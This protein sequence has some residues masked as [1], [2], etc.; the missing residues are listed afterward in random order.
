[1]ALLP[2]ILVTY[3][4]LQCIGEFPCKKC[5]DEGRICSIW[6]RK[7]CKN[8]QLTEEYAEV[9]DNTQ[10]ALVAMV[11]KLYSMVRERQPWEL[12]EPELN[13]G[14]QPIIHD[15]ASKLGCV[16]PNNN[17]TL[18][19]HSPFPEDE[20]G[21]ADLARQL[22]ERSQKECGSQISSATV[23]SR[24]PLAKTGDCLDLKQDYGKPAFGS[25][26]ASSASTPTTSPASMAHGSDSSNFNPAAFATF[27]EPGFLPGYPLEWAWVCP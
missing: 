13:D 2:P 10:H 17:L 19:V 9:L 23:S 6:A 27:S 20:A 16:Q 18:P 12:G 8:R 14:G 22:S 25:G 26:A 21:L 24:Q 15:I 5:K 11:L 4:A 7:R 3:T 1:M